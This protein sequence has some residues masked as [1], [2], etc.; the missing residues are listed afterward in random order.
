MRDSY[1]AMLRTLHVFAAVLFLGNV[2]VTG[3]W[4]ALLFPHRA[5]VPF[6]HTARAIVITDW[7]FT[8]GGAM[9]LVG[10]GVSLALA[11]GY[12]L[13]GTPWI[14]QALIGLAVSTAI[15]L[16]VLVPAQRRM[17]QLTSADDADL[18][19]TYRRWN[20]AGWVAV[21]PLLYSLWHMVTK[22]A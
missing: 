3:V 22:P 20:V 13:W 16:L 5:A 15:W 4:T 9:V 6:R 12:P 11:R 19:R 1:L 21:V 2:I 14:R 8:V 17:R 10:S 7:I 18:T